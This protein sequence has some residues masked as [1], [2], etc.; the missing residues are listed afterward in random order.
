MRKQSGGWRGADHAFDDVQAM[1][2]FARVVQSRSFTRAASELGTSTS[3]VSKRIARLEERAGAR[4]LARTTRHVAPTEAGLALYERCLR[5]LRE[6]E[7]AELLVLGLSDVPRGLLRVSAPV[8]FGELYVAPLVAGLLREQPELKLE[9]SLT[10][11]FVDLVAE[12]F[13]LAVRIGPVSSTSLMARKLAR[14]RVVAC[15]APSYLERRGRPVVPKDLLDHDCL[16]YSLDPLRNNWRFK[17]KGGSPISIPVTGGFE[18]NHGGALRQAAIAGLGIALLPLFYAVDAIER[19][20]LLTVLDEYCDAEIDIQAVYPTG[21]LLPPKT[22]ACIDWL[23][24]G[25]PEHLVPA[26]SGTRQLGRG[27]AR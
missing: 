18:C 19:G 10:D 8:Y 6:V 2:I 22:R 25:L 27:A 7:D 3:A 16:R 26:R 13:D 20:E 14:T 21:K 23:A 4:L 11:R 12:G 15:A 5:I 24:Q 9:L 17:G 1:V